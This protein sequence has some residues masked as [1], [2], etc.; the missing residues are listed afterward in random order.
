[1]N[2]A[3]LDIVLN[4]ISRVPN[5][6]TLNLFGR[7]PILDEFE[8]HLKI[9][10]NEFSKLKIQLHKGSIHVPDHESN[11][12][13]DVAYDV[14]D[15]IDEYSCF[16]GQAK[17]LSVNKRKNT[18]RKLKNRIVSVGNICLINPQSVQNEKLI[19]RG[20]EDQQKSMLTTWLKDP[21]PGRTIIPVWG[22]R[23]ESKTKLVEEVCENSEI[24]NSFQLYAHVSVPDCVQ[25]QSLLRQIADQLMGGSERI[26]DDDLLLKIQEI[27]Q[28]S[29]RYLIVLYDLNDREVWPILNFAF[30]QN[31]FANK[32]VITT[33]SQSIGSLA[34]GNHVIK[35]HSFT[36]LPSYLR[37]CILYCGL[38]PKYYLIARK[39][40]TGLWIAE[41]FLEDVSYDDKT[42]EEV[43]ED[44]LRELIEYSQLK[45]VKKDIHGKVKHFI[46]QDYVALSASR[47][48]NFG[49]ILRGSDPVVLGPNICRLFIEKS[50]EQMQF[51][52][53]K[54]V[55][56]FILFDEP[57]PSWI[58]DTLSNFES[59]QILCLR[60]TSIKVVPDA[61]Y[62]LFRLRYLDLASTMV[63]E[64]K[65]LVQN[66]KLLQ[67]LDLR[68]T[69]VR[70]L[71]KNVEKLINLQH[72]YA[73][74]PSLRAITVEG[75][76]GNL[77]FLQTLQKIKINHNWVKN[78]KS[79]RK[80]KNL[81]ITD[82][83]QNFV[84]KLLEYLSS[85]P[86][87]NKLGI[88]MYTGE[89]LNMARITSTWNLEKLYL[90]GK[91][92]ESAIPTMCGQFRMLKEFGMVMSGLCNDPLPYVS[93]MSSLVKLEINRAYDGVQ[94]VFGPDWFPNLK[95]LY[96]YEMPKLSLV[97]IDNGT[98]KNLQFLRLYFL[99]NLKNLPTGLINLEKLEDI[100]L[101]QMPDEFIR[102]A[103]FARP[104]RITRLPQPVTRLLDEVSLMHSSFMIYIL[105]NDKL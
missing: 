97:V 91:L 93:N 33:H 94:L 88:V 5:P 90:E 25:N 65:S 46:V 64:I 56:S 11:K 53:T 43:A 85:M 35:M 60:Y 39:W 15:I 47:V 42:L 70:Q 9:I 59:L 24:R 4:K 6:T 75:N 54:M 49:V 102:H 86:N 79:L 82:V 29:K 20:P 41:E 36:D 23:S 34:T 87:L 14:E 103:Q 44:Y 28:H 45:V 76:I 71:P 77:I 81:F 98:M 89:V 78:L 17:D 1:M 52:S 83:K 18:I 10:E 72:L 100:I 62:K 92:D 3:I 55:R 66:L 99:T 105:S 51:D 30:P 74:H 37:N 16:L 26:E 67:T 95:K 68:D 40:I 50:N 2:D 73:A 58:V 80:L 48:D 8:R 63:E 7:E 27:L 13:R 19:Q 38:F 101:F 57:S 32:V 61:I 69:L 96:L 12:I 31:K 104:V 21:T 84:E 22:T